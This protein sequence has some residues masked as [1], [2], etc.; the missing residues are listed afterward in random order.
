MATA[1]AGEPAVID[2]SVAAP[3][4]APRAAAGARAPLDR[5]R[6]PSAATTV[7][8][9]FPSFLHRRLLP[10]LDLYAA[11]VPRAPMVSAELI[12]PRGG[13][14]DPEGGHGLAS[15]TADL[16]DEGSELRTGPEIASWVERLG[17]SL[18]ATAD[19]D[20]SYVACTLLAEHLHDALALLAEVALL[21]TLPAT[22]LERLRKRRLA[23]LMRRR[24][25]PSALA[26]ER[27]GRALYGGGPYG[28]PLIG[29]EAE[30]RALD[31]ES[32]AAFYRQ[33]LRRGGATLIASGDLDPESVAAAAAELLAAWPQE[34]AA[35]PRPV[36]PAH[37][38]GIAVHIVDRPQAAQTELRFGHPGPPRNH[39][40]R[41]PLSVL[42]S[43]LGGKF[44]SRINLNLRERHGY[45]YGAHTSFS[46]R[47]GPGPFQVSAAVS[48]DTAG[49]ALRES[50]SELRRLHDESPAAAEL[51]D[52]VQYLTGVFPY[53]LQTVESIAQRLSQLAV[54]GLADDY[55]DRYLEE[56][57][58]VTPE[59]IRAVAR[60]HLHPEAGAVVA[61]GPAAL[62][63]PQLETFG[64]VTVWSPE[65]VA[66]SPVA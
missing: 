37:L 23:E 28:Y 66:T 32:A 65:G 22:E 34:P 53:T 54:F 15:L 46:N 39:P 45:T 64:P 27:L 49:A 21:P 31:R 56:L 62:L 52:A 57:R 36:V 5:T 12:L 30:L 41:V 17:G 40:D 47:L 25:S 59:D 7:G 26:D 61:V 50:L 43:L 9:R 11:R 48:T 10:G 55:F 19:W 16:L 4:D 58:A 42:N 51:A 35:P 18:S 13:Q 2:T 6:P 8:L 29:E 24:S 33:A 14:A 60:R 3:V 63:T 44:I 1:G 38:D 20:A